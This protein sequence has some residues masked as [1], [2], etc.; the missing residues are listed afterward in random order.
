MTTKLTPYNPEPATDGPAAC[1][2]L[3]TAAQLINLARGEAQAAMGGLEGARHARGTELLT[4]LADAQA[5]A[6]R[7][8]FVVAGDVR[9]AE[10]VDAAVQRHPAGG[11]R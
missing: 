3:S 11:A 2:K 8:T 10:A 7:L 1:S 5:F 9:A 4:K 6:E